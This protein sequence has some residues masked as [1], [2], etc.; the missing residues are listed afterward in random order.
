[1]RAQFF[2]QGNFIYIYRVNPD[3]RFSSAATGSGPWRR[4]T[5]AELIF[6]TTSSRSNPAHRESEALPSSV[7]LQRRRPHAHR[8]NTHHFRAS[9]PIF[10]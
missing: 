1:M 3:S 6:V 2:G 9:Q 7:A 8:A 5:A 10:K 4:A